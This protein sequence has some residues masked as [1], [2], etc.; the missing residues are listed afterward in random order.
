M[1]HVSVDIMGF[2]ENISN[3]AQ[4]WYWMETCI[5][6]VRFNTFM[7]DADISS[8]VWAGKTGHICFMLEFTRWWGTTSLWAC[9]C[10]SYRCGCRGLW[11]TCTCLWL[12]SFLLIFTMI[13][14]TLGFSMCLLFCYPVTVLCAIMGASSE[15]CTTWSDVNMVDTDLQAR[16]ASSTIQS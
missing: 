9:C 12:I 8:A 11:D 3:R 16:L 4:H 15:W 14:F 7:V 5:W 2:R 10:L 6:H 1:I 13:I